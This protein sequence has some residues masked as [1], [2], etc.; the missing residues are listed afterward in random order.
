MDITIN[1]FKE[2]VKKGL[3]ITELILKYDEL[4]TGLMVEQNGKYVYPKDYDAIFPDE[5]DELEFI[6]L[7]LGG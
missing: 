5:G 7:D 3:S 1:G 6:H 2:K 4:E